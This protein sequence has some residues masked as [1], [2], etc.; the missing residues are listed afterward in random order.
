MNIITSS[1]FNVLKYNYE[2]FIKLNTIEKCKPQT[3]LEPGTPGYK[4]Q[5]L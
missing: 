4:R 2:Y 5:L 1:F 3:G